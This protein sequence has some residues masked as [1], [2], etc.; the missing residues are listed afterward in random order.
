MLPHTVRQ[1]MNGNKMAEVSVTG[2]E[3][4]TP[5]DDSIFTMPKK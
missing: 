3:F 1:F 5:V 2:V 4:N